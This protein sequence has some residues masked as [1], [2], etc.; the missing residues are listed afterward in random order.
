MIKIVPY[1]FPTDL[2]TFIA[3]SKELFEIVV[4]G[5]RD[6]DNFRTVDPCFF[7]ENEID[8]ITMAH[9]TKKQLSLIQNEDDERTLEVSSKSE[10]LIVLSSI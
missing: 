5:P 8:P 9:F 2:V 10:L 4:P 1:E 7:F 3:E 6:A